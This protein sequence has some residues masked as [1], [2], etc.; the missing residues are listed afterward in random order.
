MQLDAWS[1]ENFD[2]LA[3]AAP[4]ID[5]PFVARVVS[6]MI[7]ILC[8]IIIGG[9]IFYMRSILSPSGSE[10][11]FGDR[12]SVWARWVAVATLLLIASGLFNFIVINREYK[13]VGQKLA[14]TYH[15]L[16][17]IKV[18]LSLLVFFIAAIL[19]GKTA[20]AERFRGNMSRWLNIAWTS[21]IAIVVIGA[22]MRAHHVRNPQTGEPG[23][24][25]ANEA[26]D[27]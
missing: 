24:A 2:L 15:V 18:L 22:L 3:Q 17:L 16:F 21:V 9:G 4:Q 20:A 14:M 27:G 23:P 7:H 1:L 12:R 8:A 6:R 11:C 13:E 10:A 5:G 19:A 26:A 25:P